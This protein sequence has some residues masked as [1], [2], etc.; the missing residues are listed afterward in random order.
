MDGDLVWPF[1]IPI[2]AIVGGILYATIATVSR[3]RLRELEIRERIALI[4]R[5]IV[6]PP[7]VDPR[8]FDRAMDR[9]ERYRYRGPGR[10][11]RAGIIITGVGVALIVLIG[12]TGDV[13]AAFGVCG[14][15]V[16]IG[17]AFLLNSLFDTPLDPPAPSPRSF[18]APGSTPT[19]PEPPRH[20]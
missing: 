2:S 6:P 8:G 12:F 1:L 4:E 16:V 15:M 20:D 9:Y 7:E 13:S 17:I 14:F 19:S 5:G 18:G 11:R 10:H 3:H